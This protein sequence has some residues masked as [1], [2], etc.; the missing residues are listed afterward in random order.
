[1]EFAKEEFE[2]G[3]NLLDSALFAARQRLRPIL[4]TSLAFGVGVLPLALST[5]AGRGRTQCHRHRRGGR[6][7]QRHDPRAALRAGLL[8]GGAAPVPREVE[9]S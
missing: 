5:G 7:G 9:A 3:S 6:C 8:P 4:M 2:R 1:M